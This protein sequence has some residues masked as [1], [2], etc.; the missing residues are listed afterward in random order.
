MG[1]DV[2]GIDFALVNGQMAVFAAN[3]RM[4]FFFWVIYMVIMSDI[5]IWTGT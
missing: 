2:F 5:N 4:S 3:T 1:L